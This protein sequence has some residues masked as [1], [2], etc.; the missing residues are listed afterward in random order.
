M[1]IRTRLFLGTAGLVLALMA[2]QLVLHV[3]Q[4]RAIERALGVVATSVGRDLL[5]HGFGFVAGGGATTGGTWVDAAS[6]AADDDA[7]PS[8][9]QRARI[10]VL[11]ERHA[12]PAAGPAPSTAPASR[13]SGGDAAGHDGVDGGGG[14]MV[15]H[16]RQAPGGEDGEPDRPGRGSLQRIELKVVA[17]RG[18]PDRFLVLRS[19]GGDE[20]RIPIPVAPAIRVFHDTLRGSLLTGGGLLLLGLVG[21]GVLADRLVRPLSRLAERSEALGRGDLGVQVEEDAGGEV[22][23]LQRA[24]NRMS[25]RLAALERER[26]QWRQR[27]HLAELGDVARGLAHTV[28]NPLNTLGLTVEELAADHAENDVLVTTARAQIRRIDGWL[29]SFLALGAGE[30]AERSREDVRDVLDE[31]LVAVA[32][33]DGVTVAG[34]GRTLP[35]E[36]VPSAIRAALVNLLENALQASPAGVPVAVSVERAGGWARVTI[37]DAGPGLPDEVRRRLFEPHVTTRA[38]GSGMGL[39]LAHQLI[40]TMHGGTL[41]VGTAPGGGTEAVVSLP[42]M[43]AEEAGA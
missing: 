38:G 20:R 41:E 31:A 37:R 10:V 3:R 33:H 9:G 1:Q 5:E 30:G 39:Y 36:V 43:P 22:G 4:V 24:F 27:A 18:Q 23:D 28:R 40:V 15:W 2:V 8:D 17:E 21:S 29:R 6:G 25:S 32:Q 12:T 7:E 42:L 14:L 26:E 13:P 35:V 11:E 19:D 34:D 16:S